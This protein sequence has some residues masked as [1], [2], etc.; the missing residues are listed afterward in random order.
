MPRAV[1]AVI[2]ADLA[3][4]AIADACCLSA[5]FW[6]DA[7]ITIQMSD[8]ADRAH[9]ILVDD[10]PT[11]VNALRLHG[12]G[13]AAAIDSFGIVAV[14]HEPLERSAIVSQ[15]RTFGGALERPAGAQ[16]YPYCAAAPPKARFVAS[17]DIIRTVRRH[18]RFARCSNGG[19]LRWALRQSS[20]PSGARCRTS[21]SRNWLDP[22]RLRTAAVD[23]ASC[24]AQHG[25]PQCDPATQASR[26]ALAHARRLACLAMRLWFQSGCLVV[27]TWTTT[28]IDSV[29]RSF[30]A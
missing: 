22:W 15:T 16:M 21:R 26:H 25:E 9:G 6:Q 19:F 17:A 18:A 3:V 7:S 23:A 2:S 30:P 10:R 29:V 1:V 14:A 5:T 27:N 8:F 20:G 28:P 12:V 13:S 11:T 4:A 24:K